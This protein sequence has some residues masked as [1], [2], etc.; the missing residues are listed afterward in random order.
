MLSDLATAAGARLG[1]DGPV[2]S[3][4]RPAY[5][6]CLHAIYGRRGVPWHVNGES[7]R[8]V[9]GVRHL[10]PHENEPSLFNFLRAE[11]RPGD[12]VFDVGSFLGT[13]AVMA[14]RWAGPQGRVVAFEPSPETFHLLERHLAMNGVARQVVARLAAVGERAGRRELMVFRDEPYRNMLATG[15][16]TSSSAIAD[17]IT[18]DEAARE[19][20]R[21][22]D[23]IRMDVQGAEFD[24][25]AGAQTLLRERRRP[26]RIVAE[27]HPEQWPDFGVSP[28]EAADRLASLGLWARSLVP[29]EPVW[30]QGAHAILEPLR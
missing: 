14:A 27:M 10:V 19:L 16:K 11:I 15:G 30:S 18:L 25:L 2:V 21:P 24:V 5:A 9:P 8:I 26:V 3:L 17:V 6:R 1:R 4:V 13:Y 23:W 20:G 12:V 28:A 7:I 29:G 22:P